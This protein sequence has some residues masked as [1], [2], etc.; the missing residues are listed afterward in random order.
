VGT[1]DDEKKAM[2]FLKKATCKPINAVA[3]TNISR[4]V[5]LVK[6]CNAMVTGDSSPMHIAAAVNTPFVAIFGPTD[7]RKHL[8]FAEKYR[9]IYK[10]L[11]CSPCYRPACV[12]GYKCVR[13]VTGEEVF[14]RLMELIK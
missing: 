9:V 1:K 14:E 8:P 13:S 2:E 11:K 4:L 6:R 12:V 10:N 7:P 5:G 3:R